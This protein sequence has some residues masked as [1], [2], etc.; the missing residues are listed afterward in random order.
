MLDRR[1]AP[2]GA[3]VTQTLSVPPY[4]TRLVVPG[5]RWLLL[6]LSHSSTCPTLP[7]PMDTASRL[8]HRVFK[9]KY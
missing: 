2:G 9:Q 4:P 6:L 5:M 8:L 1:W 7:D 3:H